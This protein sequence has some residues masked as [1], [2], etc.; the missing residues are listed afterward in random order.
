MNTWMAPI[1]M[2]VDEAKRPLQFR[3][4]HLLVLTTIFALFTVVATLV[5]WR[6]TLRP[7]NQ[8]VYLLTGA[9]WAS[10]AVLLGKLVRRGAIGGAVIANLLIVDSI[11]RSYQPAD[12]EMIGHGCEA[13]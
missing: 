1:V 2:P 3:I 9:A 12:E 6:G 13:A 4:Q 11:T 5:T 7:W 8:A 10:N